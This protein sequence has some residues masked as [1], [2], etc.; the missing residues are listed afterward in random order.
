MHNV[1]LYVCLRFV[2]T[3]HKFVSSFLFPLYYFH[4]F[5]SHFRISLC[6][7]FFQCAIQYIQRFVLFKI[8]TWNSMVHHHKR[9]RGFCIT[10][11]ITISV[12]YYQQNSKHFELLRNKNIQTSVIYT[13]CVLCVQKN[14]YFY[15]L[16]VF[17]SPFSF[18][19]MF[20]LLRFL[21]ACKIDR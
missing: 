13:Y 16:S 18:A 14:H 20:F 1:Y 17:E 10:V 4:L 15:T 11:L 6:F 3:L 8:A 21:F 5:F 7:Y 9:N 19:F 12:S 2:Y